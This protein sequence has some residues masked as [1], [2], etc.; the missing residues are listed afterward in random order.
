MV[1]M[2]PADLVVIRFFGMRLESDPAGVVEVDD[3]EVEAV[4]SLMQR[5]G[6]LLA[7]IRREHDP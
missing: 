1:S 3:T 6:K 5:R 2:G 7:R 4:P